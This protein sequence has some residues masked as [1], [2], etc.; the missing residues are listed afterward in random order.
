MTAAALRYQWSQVEFLRAHEAAV[1]DG[2]AELVEGQVWPVVIGGWHGTTTARLVHLVTA[3]GGSA[4]DGRAAPALVTQESLVTGA[5]LPDPDLWVRRADARPVEELTDRVQRWAAADVL[6]VVEVADQSLADD[7]STKA[8]LYGSAGYAVYWVVTREALHE[9]T[10][11]D[12]QGY[13]TVT[14]YSRGDEVP[15]RHASGALAVS[16][17]LGPET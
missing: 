1:F 2:R 7:L 16:E 11:P 8:R 5:S 9:H 3:A 14:R 13:R 12:A 15:L 6:L 17:V 10:S 4:P